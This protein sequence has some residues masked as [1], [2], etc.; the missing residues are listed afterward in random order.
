MNITTQNDAGNNESISVISI[1]GLLDACG[2]T[3]THVSNQETKPDEQQPETEV[4][5]VDKSNLNQYILNYSNINKADYTEESYK[6][7]YD[8]LTNARNINQDESATQEEVDNAVNQ[9]NTA[10]DI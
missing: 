7:F 4:S 3:Y 5:T 9:L 1:T 2:I 10:K 6:T 8:A